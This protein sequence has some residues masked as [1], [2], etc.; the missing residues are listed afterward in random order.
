[1]KS[2][3]SSLLLGLFLIFSGTA[4]SEEITITGETSVNS[5]TTFTYYATP[6]TPIE[7]GTTYTWEVYD[8]TIVAQNTDPTAGP[9]YCTVRF[10]AILAQ[11]AIEITDN[12][13]NSGRLFVTI[14]GFSS[15]VQQNS[16][17]FTDAPFARL[18]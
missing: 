2:K 1:M 12:H 9:L 10:P 4:F 17:I 18:C 7:P 8:A 14:N 3:A 13:G 6:A 15:L 5:S 11:S 16:R